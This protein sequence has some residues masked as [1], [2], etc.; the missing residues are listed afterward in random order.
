LAPTAARVGKPRTKSSPV[1]TGADPAAF[2]AA[3]RPDDCLIFGVADAP[4]ADD[5][6][7]RE[8]RT[9]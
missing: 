7:R 9:N 3:A 1:G 8:S 2:I 5:L 4:A 6:R